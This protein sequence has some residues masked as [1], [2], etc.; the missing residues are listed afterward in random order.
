M[1]IQP[2]APG[3]TSGTGPGRIDRAPT[4]AP[5]R[6]D[7]RSSPRLAPPGV[8]RDDIEISAVARDLQ[9]T[10]GSDA[11]A[12][13]DLPPARMRQ[14]LDRIAS[15]YYDRPEVRDQVL[16]SLAD[17]LGNNSSQD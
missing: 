4:G 3:R 5:V 16:K 7:G 8:K 11:V 10:A 14:I 17:A 15:G 9:E 2:T 12:G 13:S 1:D 6:P